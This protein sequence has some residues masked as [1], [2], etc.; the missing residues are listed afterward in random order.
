MAALLNDG[1]VPYG[2]RVLNI[3][4]RNYV[5]T[6]IELTRTVEV[7]ERFNEVGEPSG[8]VLIPRWV[9]GTAT[10]QLSGSV[11]IL[12]AQG[13]TFSASFSGSSENF[14]VSELTQPESQLADKVVRITFRKTYNF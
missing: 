14:M 8:Q 13:G 10:L 1:T 2:S 6:D 9:T 11:P 7:I 5:A 12:P 4:S 3:N